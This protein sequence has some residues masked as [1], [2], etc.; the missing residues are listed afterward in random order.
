VPVEVNPPLTLAVGGAPVIVA[1][2]LAP[3]P[4]NTKVGVAV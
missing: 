1:G 2:V 3:P 4:L